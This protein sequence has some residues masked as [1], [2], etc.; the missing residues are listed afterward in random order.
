MTITATAG[1]TVQAGDQYDFA[2]YD[3]SDGNTRVNNSP[4]LFTDASDGLHLGADL[5]TGNYK[6]TS[7]SGS[8]QFDKEIII[9]NYASGSIPTG[10]NGMIVYNTTT[11]KLQVYANGSWV[12]LH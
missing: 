10:S 6:I 9:K 1:G 8:V 12:D 11:N 3:L 5:D 7:L 2:Y 4:A